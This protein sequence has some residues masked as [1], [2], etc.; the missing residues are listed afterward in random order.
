MKS[1]HQTLVLCA[2]LLFVA[3]VA[4]QTFAPKTASPE[5]WRFRTMKAR[6]GC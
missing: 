1:L 5:I 2:L 6:L 4:A 3:P